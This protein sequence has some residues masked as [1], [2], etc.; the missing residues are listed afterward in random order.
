MQEKTKVNLFE[1]VEI[2]LAC[3]AWFQF[4]HGE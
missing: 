4:C 2:D 3:D 1:P